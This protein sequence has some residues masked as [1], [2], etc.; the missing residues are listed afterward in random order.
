MATR[1]VPRGLEDAKRELEN[2][3]GKTRRG[4]SLRPARSLSRHLQGN[5]SIGKR[6]YDRKTKERYDM[7]DAAALQRRIAEAAMA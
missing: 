5:G 1:N 2:E 6:I 4:E 3:R 7:A